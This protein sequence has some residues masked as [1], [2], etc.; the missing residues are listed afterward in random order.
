MAKRMIPQLVIYKFNFLTTIIAKYFVKIK[1]GNLINIFANRMIIPELTNF[2][3]TTKKFTNEFELLINNEKRNHEQL[4]QIQDNIKYFE[5]NQ[6]P[7]DL[8]VNRIMELI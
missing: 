2:N 5:N 6:S 8:C 1:Y 7:Y 3:L 4:F